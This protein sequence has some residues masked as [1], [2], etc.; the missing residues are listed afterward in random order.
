MTGLVADLLSLSRVEA[1]EK[2]RPRTPVSIM[3]LKAHAGRA[4]PAD[5]AACAVDAQCPPIC[6]ISPAIMTNWCKSITT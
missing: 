4:A 1:V 2:I 3:V 5:R 6:P